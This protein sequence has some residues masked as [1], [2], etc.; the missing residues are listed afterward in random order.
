MRARMI[1]VAM[2]GLGPL[3]LACA[4]P[5]TVSDLG[6]T[7]AL[8]PDVSVRQEWKQPPT[9][10][11]VLPQPAFL[12]LFVV[13]PDH[14]AE[15]VPLATADAPFAA[16]AHV[17]RP[18][19]AEARRQNGPAAAGGTYPDYAAPCAVQDFVKETIQTTTGPGGVEQKTD[20]ITFSTPTTSPPIVTCA[21]PG[22]EELGATSRPTFDRYLL[23][24]ATDKAMATSAVA[25]ALS[26]LDVSGSPREVTERVA[27][28][29]AREAG[30]TQWGARAVR[31]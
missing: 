5:S 8:G 27:T 13:S 16:G 24:V 19:P 6:T 12:T 23:V 18:V 4:P 17:L 11:V 20:V 25:R 14:S 29:A 3:S 31:Y 1:F 2:L 21:V 15:L 30:A 9:F 10:T 7:P 28:L 22:F 26:G